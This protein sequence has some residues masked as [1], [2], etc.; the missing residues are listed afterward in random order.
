MEQDKQITLAQDNI[1]TQSRQNFKVIEKRCLYQ[2]IREVRS[3]YIDSHT[4]NK[5]LFD[6]MILELQPSMLMQL[7]DEVKDVYSALKALS[8]KEIEIETE[9]EWIFT[10]WVLQAKHDKKRNVY[11]VDVSRDRKS[12]V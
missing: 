9:N 6:N 11:V 10:H 4:G 5:D 1:L 7:G 8:R 12:V 2:I 3:K